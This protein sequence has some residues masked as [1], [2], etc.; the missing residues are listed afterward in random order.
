MT[1]NERRISYFLE[2]SHPFTEANPWNELESRAI[3][4]LITVFYTGGA[5]FDDQFESWALIE[6]TAAVAQ[7]LQE[8]Y[9]VRDTVRAIYVAPT[10]RE[11]VVAD[12]GAVVERVEEADHEF[13]QMLRDRQDII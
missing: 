13:V 5:D 11:F 7:E 3:Q 1:A 2:I 8:F 10:G 9:S 12:P 4:G 6:T